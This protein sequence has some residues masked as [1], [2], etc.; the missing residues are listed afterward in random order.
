MFTE[1]TIEELISLVGVEVTQQLI[2]ART[3]NTTLKPKDKDLLTPGN[4]TKRIAKR[5]KRAYACNID[6]ALS[7]V[8]TACDINLMHE[9]MVSLNGMGGSRVKPISEILKERGLL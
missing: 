3:I 7:L 9:Q 4:Y 2:S 1:Q 8:D 6:Y 5:L